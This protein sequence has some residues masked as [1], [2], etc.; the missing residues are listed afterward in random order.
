[1]PT[2]VNFQRP[3]HRCNVAVKF[4]LI[5][6]SACTGAGLF[7]AAGVGFGV[8]VR[9]ARGVAV[10]N[11]MIVACAVGIGPAVFTGLGVGSEEGAGPT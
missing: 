11:G 5:V 9:E 2:T 8:G 7:D 1:V 6:M 10:G 3:D 4:P